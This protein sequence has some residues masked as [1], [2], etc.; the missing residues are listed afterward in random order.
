Q[1]HFGFYRLVSWILH[2]VDSWLDK[3]TPAR[4]LAL[5]R[6]VAGPEPVTSLAWSKPVPTAVPAIL[7]LKGITAR[8]FALINDQTLARNESGKVRIG[9]SNVVVKCL[10]IRD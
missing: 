5:N 6:E 2:G 7:L 3:A 9:S 4:V 1:Q 8:R 10:E